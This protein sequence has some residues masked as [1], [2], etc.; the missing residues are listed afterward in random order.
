MDWTE[1]DQDKFPFERLPENVQARIVRF[2]GRPSSKRTT[3]RINQAMQVDFLQNECLIPITTKEVSKYELINHPYTICSFFNYSAKGTKNLYAM[4]LSRDNSKKLAAPYG[5]LF[6]GMVENNRGDVKI[7]EINI[8]DD[9]N[10][11]EASKGQPVGY[12]LVTTYYVLKARASC[13][14]YF[15]GFAKKAIIDTLDSLYNSE[16]THELLVFLRANAAVMGVIKGKYFPTMYHVQSKDDLDNLSSFIAEEISHLYTKIRRSLM[17]IDDEYYNPH[18]EP[19][20]VM[21]YSI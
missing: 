11:I 13:A 4:L 7:G 12:D 8:E 2:G 15:S 14:T 10:M 1:I 18:L 3:N 17:V 21:D 19:K 5:S 20:Y 9:H 16:A 6:I